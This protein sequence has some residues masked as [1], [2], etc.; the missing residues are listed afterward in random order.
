[1]RLRLPSLLAALGLLLAACTAI[2]AGRAGNPTCRSPTPRRRR[3]QAVRRPPACSCRRGRQPLGPR[4]RTAVRRPGQ[5]ATPRRSAIAVAS[6]VREQEPWLPLNLH[7]RAGLYA[8]SHPCPFHHQNPSA[9][10][11]VTWGEG[12]GRYTSALIPS[13]ASRYLV[14]ATGAR[15]SASPTT[16]VN[17]PKC[18]SQ[19][20]VLLCR[21]I[22]LMATALGCRPI[23]DRVGVRAD[24]LKSH[25]GFTSGS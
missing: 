16:R 1:M 13:S 22:S 9:E 6:R 11:P 20:F 12:M 5:P 3:D 24:K 18:V 8:G 14:E 2:C 4:L 7:N 23:R 25:D 15:H 17:H 10:N 21:G 19:D